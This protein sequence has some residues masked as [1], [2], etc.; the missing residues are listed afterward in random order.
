MSNQDLSI[1]DVVR[2]QIQE[3]WPDLPNQILNPG[4]AGLG[5]WG[6]EIRAVGTGPIVGKIS[7]YVQ[8]GTSFGLLEFGVKSGVD[9][10]PAYG[11]AAVWRIDI[12]P[13]LAAGQQFRASAYV[14]GMPPDEGN[15]GTFGVRLISPDDTNDFAFPDPLDIGVNELPPTDLPI[16]TTEIEFFHLLPTGATSGTIQFNQAT[17]VFGDAADVAASDPASEPSWVDILA[18]AGEIVLEREE[19]NVGTLNATL[20]DTDLDPATNDLIRPGKRFRLEALIDGDWESLGRGK[21][22]NPSSTYEVKDPRIP[23]AK[24]VNIKLTATDVA[25]DLANTPQPRGVASFAELPM[26]MLGTDVPLKVNGT[27]PSGVDIDAIEVAG[28]ND[29]ASVLD[30]IVITRDSVQGYAWLDRDGT[31]QAWDRAELPSAVVLDIDETDYIDLVPDFDVDRTFNTLTVELV[32]PDGTADTYGPYVDGANRRAW[33]DRTA[34]WRVQGINPDD[35]PAFAYSVLALNA[36]PTKRIKTAILPIRNAT[37]LEAY[38]LLDLYDLVTVSSDRALIT[39]QHSRIVSI[40]HHMNIRRSGKETVNRWSVELGF[41]PDTTVPVP[42]VTS[43]PA[44]S[45]SKVRTIAAGASGVFNPR[46][47][48]AVSD[49]DVDA[50]DI[51]REAIFEAGEVGMGT[52]LVDRRLGWT[53]DLVVPKNVLLR[54]TG[55]VAGGEGGLLALDDTSRLCIGE[56]ASGNERSAGARDL[57]IDGN[58]TGHPDGLVKVEAVLAKMEGISIKDAAGIGLLVNAAQNMLMDSVDVTHCGVANVRII[59]GAG[60]LKWLRCENTPGATGAA[61]II[62][63]PDGSANNAYPFGSAH[64]Q[65]DQCIF[66]AYQDNDAEHFIHIDAGGALRFTSC[67]FSN[68]NKTLA[69]EALIDVSN[70]SFPTI[71]TVVELNSCN[72]NGGNVDRTPAVRIVGNNRV[73]VTGEC[74]WQQHDPIFI[75][76][77]GSGQLMWDSTNLYGGGVPAAGSRIV[78][79]NGGNSFGRVVDREMGHRY[80][81]GDADTYPIATR[82]DDDAPGGL[83]GALTRDGGL[84]FGDGTNYT[85]RDSL[86]YLPADDHIAATTMMVV[87]RRGSY[88]SPL[89][90][91][92]GALNLDSRAYSFH[93]IALGVVGAGNITSMTVSNPTDGAEIDIF[94]IDASGGHTITWPTNFVWQGGGTGPVGTADFLHRRFKYFNAASKWYQIG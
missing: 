18:S 60:G 42:Q 86:G 38:A 78:D 73:I 74:Y 28:Y 34:T 15:R 82:R 56:W 16:G 19:I 79:I 55:N 70:A 3:D 76:D 44:V 80:R 58:D 51:I 52:V 9:L 13:V 36:T 63:D 91:P 14:G 20:Y 85:V 5:A 90:T 41:A 46:M 2:L 81:I 49:P 92:N 71:Q 30:Q 48:G 72:Y 75:Q 11:A 93:Q 22:E 62:E 77:T 26:V 27:I 23:D 47:M 89:R 66:E 33:R 37:E 17:F 69:A 94:I 39:D 29:S 1:I 54:S 84:V 10:P 45:F 43:S 61:L 12:A 6:W 67:G 8:L 31:L 35:I 25:S 88:P 50:G 24:R 83:R 4:S 59:N 68:N 57:L 32:H 40:K 65:W 7:D 64:I 21:L 53:G 87:G